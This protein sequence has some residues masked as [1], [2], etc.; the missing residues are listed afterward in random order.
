MFSFNNI[1]IEVLSQNRLS[2]IKFFLTEINSD[3]IIQLKFHFCRLSERSCIEIVQKL[4][5]LKIIEVVYTTDGKEYLT[6]QELGKEIREELT[7]RGGLTA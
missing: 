1:V 2:S 7:V 6:P 4:I 5:E 3:F